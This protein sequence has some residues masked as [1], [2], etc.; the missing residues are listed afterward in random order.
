MSSVLG[1]KF[2]FRSLNMGPDGGHSNREALTDLLV[3]QARGE[4]M[5]DRSFLIREGS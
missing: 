5:E 3:V 4:Q 1:A 2:G